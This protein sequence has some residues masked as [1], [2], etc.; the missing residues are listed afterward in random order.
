MKR[1]IKSD[2]TV[3]VQSIETMQVIINEEQG[4]INLRYIVMSLCDDRG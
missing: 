3:S 1:S 4:L 2:K